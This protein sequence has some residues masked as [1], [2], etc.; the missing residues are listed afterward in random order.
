VS[1]LDAINNLTATI[2]RDGL[3]RRGESNRVLAVGVA[4]LV[5]LVL[6]VAVLLQNRSRSLQN[7][8]ILKNSAATSEYIAD[9]TTPGR[10]CYQK[11]LAN[12]GALLTRLLTSEAFVA[13]CA[14]VT[15]TDDEL[16]TCVNERLKAA[17]I[18]LQLDLSTAPPEPGPAAPD[19]SPTPAE[20]QDSDVT[21]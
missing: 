2:K 1:H 6:N 21:P 4:L 14:K 10:P 12:Q 7:G 13:Q 17:G 8:E 16:E 19:P 15:N 18:G 5:L 20:A 3:D 11:N 9:C